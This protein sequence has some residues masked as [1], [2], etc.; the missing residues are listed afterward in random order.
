[1][2]CRSS[3]QGCSLIKTTYAV[4]LFSIITGIIS[5]NNDKK[6]HQ[7]VL[8]KYQADTDSCLTQVH[9]LQQMFTA[10]KP[11]QLLRQQFLAVRK[12]YKRIEIFAEYYNPTTAKSINGPAITEVE[13]DNPDYPQEPHGLQVIESF[14]YPEINLDT[15]AFVQELEMLLTTLNRL[16]VTSS[17]LQL[18]DGHVWDAIRLELFRISSLSLS[19]FDTPLSLS[20]IDELPIC[21]ES[22]KSYIKFYELDEKVYDSLLTYLDNA[23]DYA[24]AQKDFNHF[25]RAAFLRSFLHPIGRYLYET[26]QM[27]NIP[28]FSEKRL[29]SE[30]AKTFFDSAVF[31][32]WSYAPDLKQVHNASEVALGKMLFNENRLSGNNTRSCGSC[33]QEAKAFT[34]G[35]PKNKTFDGSRIIMRNTPTILYAALQPALFADS[36]VAYLEDQARQVTENPDEMHGNLSKAATLLSTDK[37]YKAVFAKVY[38]SDTISG[39]HIQKAL[40]A[41]IRSKSNFSSAFDAYMRGNDT[42]IDADAIKGFNVFMGKAKCGTCHFMPLFNGNVPPGYSKIESEVLGVPAANKAPFRLDDDKGKYDYIKSAPYLNAFKTPTV[43]NAAVTAPYMHNGSFQD[44]EAVIHFYDIGGGAGLKIQ[45][46]NQTLQPDSL[47][48]TMNEKNQLKAFME[49]LSDRSY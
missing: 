40:A 22:I 31:N 19:G 48:L 32:P 43:R 12:S 36:R 1:M 46:A 38:Q 25:D 35:L 8:Q 45:P 39:L 28:F 24:A 23:I 6:S 44:L 21:L 2:F 17:A 30:K 26:Q 14:L 5:C 20:A 27:A 15:T 37:N 42:A 47:H 9:L 49:S 16:K 7:L 34:D 10:G 33:H 29:L 41:Y 3:Y 4:L 13:F 11:G 18:T